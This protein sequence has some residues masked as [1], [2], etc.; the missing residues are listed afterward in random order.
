PEDVIRTATTRIENFSDAI[1][2]KYDIALSSLAYH[3]MPLE[4]KLMHLEKMRQWIDHFIIFEIDAN[5]D[6]PE[7]HTPELALS[8]Y[9]SYGKIMDF[10]F[11]HDAPMEVVIPCIDSFLMSEAVSLLTQARG[12]RNDYHALRGQWHDVFMRGLGK[13]FTCLSDS[14]CYGDEYMCLFT[15]HYGK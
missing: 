11:A 7:L 15:M 13:D 9:Q 10:V 3:H 2:H 12:V 1:D 8:V 14:T 5:N 6:T 4:T